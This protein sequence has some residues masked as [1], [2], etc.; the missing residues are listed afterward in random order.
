MNSDRELRRK[1]QEEEEEDEE[2]VGFV[3]KIWHI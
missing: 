1:G 2:C 3:E